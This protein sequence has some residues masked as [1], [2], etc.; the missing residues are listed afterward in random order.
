MNQILKIAQLPVKERLRRLDSW[1]VDASKQGKHVVFSASRT[2]RGKEWEISSKRT[3]MQKFLDIRTSDQALTF[4]Q[5]F[6]P[7]QR[8]KGATNEQAKEDAIPPPIHNDREIPGAL[9]RFHQSAP[10]PQCF[11]G[12]DSLEKALLIDSHDRPLAPRGDGIRETE[13]NEVSVAISAASRD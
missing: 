10:V 11:V 5:K 7:F 13:G 4:F 12:S 6:G 1:D 9:P 2:T 3:P 8:V